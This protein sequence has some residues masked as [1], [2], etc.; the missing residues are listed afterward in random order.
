MARNPNDGA[1]GLFESL[2]TLSGTVVGVVRTR[3]Q[4]LSTDIAEE[5]ERAISLMVL[6]LVALFCLGLGTVLLSVL[7]VIAYWESHRF[8]ALGALA[9]VFLVASAG[10]VWLALHRVQTGPPLFAATR[11]E[12]SKDRRPRGS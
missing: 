12:L 7:I 11:T 6:G 5:R 2:K 1:G 10:A 9:G 4:L 8:L 3:F